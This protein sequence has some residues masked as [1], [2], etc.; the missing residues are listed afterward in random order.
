MFLMIWI[1]YLGK[2]SNYF[3]RTFLCVNDYSSNNKMFLTNTYL[4]VQ[5]RRIS[6]M[7]VP[8]CTRNTWI[9]IR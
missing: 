4:E 6:D 2:C 8:H 1:V 5:F 3:Y 9:V 7:K